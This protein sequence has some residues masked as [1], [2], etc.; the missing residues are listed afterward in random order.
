MG[1]EH[2]AARAQAS[3]A[4]VPMLSER[5]RLVYPLFGLKWAMILLNDFLPER[6]SQAQ[7]Q[8]E[9]RLTQLRKAQALVG[10]LAAE[11]RDNPYLD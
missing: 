5:T 6:F 2:F 3:F 8:S 9:W 4:D 10:R 11:Y 1:T 7:G